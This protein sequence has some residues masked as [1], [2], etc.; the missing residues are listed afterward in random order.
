MKKFEEY[1]SQYLKENPEEDWGDDDV[2]MVFDSTP[3][4]QMLNDLAEKIEELEDYQNH[5]L[6]HCQCD[7][8]IEP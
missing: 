5:L 2:E 6:E 8:D 7:K 4:I 3:A 1:L